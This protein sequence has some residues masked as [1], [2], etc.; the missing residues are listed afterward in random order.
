M[1]CVTYVREAPVIV[2][3][4]VDNEVAGVVDQL[5]NV[6]VAFPGNV[7]AINGEVDFSEVEDSWSVVSVD[8]L[9]EGTSDADS[10]AGWCEVAVGAND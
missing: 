3:F 4:V 7:V 1:F 2:S 5:D 8:G 9:V 6:D 10:V